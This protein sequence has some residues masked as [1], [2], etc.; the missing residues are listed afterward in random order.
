MIVSAKQRG[1][2]QLHADSRKPEGTVLAKAVGDLVARLK[3]RGGLDDTLIVFMSDNGGN[4]ELGPKGRT[5]GNPDWFCGMSWAFVENTPFRL[6]K[7]YNHEGGVSSPFIAHW[8]A[9]IAAKGEIRAQPA[10]VIDIMSTC[11]A[12]GGATYPKE[13][14]G[15]PITPM[16]GRSLVGAFANEPTGRASCSSAESSIFT[17]YDPR[18]SI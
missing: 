13:F 14:K 5:K 3:Q 18:R 1:T 7:H 17:H 16:E 2:Q 9:G 6:F 11:A 12:V 4:A 10:H 15:R 8:P